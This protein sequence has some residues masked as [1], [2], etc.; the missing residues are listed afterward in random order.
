[1]VV[2]LGFSPPVVEKAQCTDCIY[3]VG[4]NTAHHPRFV[5]VIGSFFTIGLNSGEFMQ[6]RTQLGTALHR[7]KVLPLGQVKA[8]LV[9]WH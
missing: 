7:L 4:Q 3:V 1:M 9:A 8:E 6:V 5:T 2:G